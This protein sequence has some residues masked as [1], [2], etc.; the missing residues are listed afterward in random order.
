[1]GRNIK[2]N[3]SYP[4]G[5]FPRLCLIGNSNVGKSS[6]TKLL[7]SHPKWYKGKVGKTAGSTVR[8]TI[9]NDPKLNYHVIDLPGFGRMIKL[10]RS[11]EEFI[12]NQILKYLRL[13]R[14]NI[15]LTL[16]VIAVDRLQDELEKWYFKNENT[17]PLSIE[18]IQYFVKNE[19]PCLIILNK[20]DKL[21]KFQR[22]DIKKTFFNVL[23][24][25]NI[26][27]DNSKSKQSVLDVIECS[28]K[29]L[30]GI[31]EIKQNI[32]EISSHLQLENYDPRSELLNLP[33]IN[34]KKKGKKGNQTTKSK[35]N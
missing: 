20:I 10:S 30:Q 7:L 25:F 28:T 24:D 18:F 11:S 32:K 3:F 31:K 22:E 23:S 17:I 27:I 1:M 2:T 14:N 15:F 16:L 19:I 21:N 8:L 35:N 5:N 34:A 29:T 26:E 9:I 33:P 12:Q 6:L 13:D 4:R